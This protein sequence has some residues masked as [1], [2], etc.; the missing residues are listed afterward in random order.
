MV[1]ETKNIIN[2]ILEI[3]QNNA[4]FKKLTGEFRFG[5]QVDSKN[6]YDC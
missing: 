4:D 3:L 6:N 5:D 2:R 1:L